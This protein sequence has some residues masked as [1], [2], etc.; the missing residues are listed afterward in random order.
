MCLYVA[1]LAA[2][3]R[4]GHMLKTWRCGEDMAG[5]GVGLQHSDTVQSL[6]PDTAMP[7]VKLL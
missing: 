4:W 3:S 1:R 2:V 7:P 5:H 6:C